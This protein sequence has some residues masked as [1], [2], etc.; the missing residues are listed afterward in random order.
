MDTLEL[1]NRSIL[2]EADTD[3]EWFP[4]TE[5]LISIE[6]AA[7]ILEVKPATF[8]KIAAEES[9]RIITDNNGT[10]VIKK[11]DLQAFFNRKKYCNRPVLDIEK[12]H[13]N[14]EKPN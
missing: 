5:E 13:K 6:I 7:K 10:S 14:P 2:F 1:L 4:C 11:T 12:P 3:I 8:Y 9:M